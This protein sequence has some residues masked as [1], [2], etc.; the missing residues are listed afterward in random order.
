[1]P[2]LF[3]PADINEISRGIKFIENLLI[4]CRIKGKAKNQALLISEE[5]LVRLI[6][7]ASEGAEI[8]INVHRF[9]S[10]ANIT[11]S[12]AGKPMDSDDLQLDLSAGE[13]GHD[14]EEAIRSMLL[15]AFSDRMAYVRKGEYNF[16]K[17]NAGYKERV[18]AI[19]TTAAL[20]LALICSLLLIPLLPENVSLWIRDQFLAPIQQIFIN[21]L[22]LVT[23]PAVFFSTTTAVAQ[24]TAFSDPG[25]VSGKVIIG[26]F[27]TSVLAVFMGFGL[28]Q[29]IDPG[30][31]SAMIFR[32]MAYVRQIDQI[33]PENA[34]LIERIV[35]FIPNNVVAPFMNTDAVQLLVVALLAGLALGRAGGYSYKL[36]DLSEALNRFFTVMVEIVA[37]LIPPATFFI[38]LLTLST[39]RVSALIAGAEIFGM[40]LLGLF[41]LL[42]FYLLLVAFA[43]RL[44][45]LTFIRKYWRHMWNTF[46][47]GSS[48]SA[49]PDS[50]RCCEK[51]FGVSPSV[52]AFSIPFGAISNLDGSCIYLTIA[53][54]FLAKICGVNLLGKDILTIG[55]MVIV[56]SIGSTITPGSVLLALAMLMNEMNISLSALSILLGIN[57][58]IEMFL[59]MCNTAGDVAMTLV[60]S[61]TENLLDIETYKK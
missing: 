61:R 33:I 35:N 22:Q 56:L 53:G 18:F 31:N 60:I 4:Q 44:N 41:C 21:M 51:D 28:F 6:E 32:S 57:A 46:F 55:F 17:I 10:T 13:I 49:I 36:L 23:A 39:F 29:L 37:K 8:E 19:R 58:L 50:I 54:L 1:M 38:S 7:N 47:A 42:I 2:K 15:R 27:I 30:E 45:P 16:I 14:S 11:I 26:Y 25:K 20:L 34:G 5:S 48:I 40:V 12:A 3:I 52:T 59:A 43:G 9:Y 24:F